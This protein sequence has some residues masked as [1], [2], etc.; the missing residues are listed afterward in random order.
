[1]HHNDLI[2]LT[3]STLLYRR[4]L[5][6]FFPLLCTLTVVWEREKETLYCV[7]QALTW[8]FPN[9]FS[10]C[11]YS[12]AAWLAR[13][14]GTKGNML[15]TARQG[16]PVIICE[17]KK[18]HLHSRRGLESTFIAFFSPSSLLSGVVTWTGSQLKPLEVSG[19]VVLLH[20][21]LQFPVVSVLSR[22]R[23]SSSHTELLN[24]QP[25]VGQ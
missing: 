7:M 12:F 4:F 21:K 22:A 24:K 3:R 20:R 16:T 11:L 10:G 5:C 13:S 1:M 8:Q 6:T 17:V 19:S 23:V 15:F 2:Y 18:I 14:G 25:F 9:R